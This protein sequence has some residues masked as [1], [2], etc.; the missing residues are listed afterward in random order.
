MKVKYGDKV[1]EYDYKTISVPT[2][3]HE[4]LKALASKENIS[5]TR[6]LRKH[7]K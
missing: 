6:F 4:K 5:I 1:Y 2:K 7:F 3:L